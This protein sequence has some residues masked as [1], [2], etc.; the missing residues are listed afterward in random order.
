M[1]KELKISLFILIQVL[2]LNICFA[3]SNFEIANKYY[4]EDNYPSAKYY[5]EDSLFNEG[6]QNG[7]LFYRLGYSYEQLKF[8]KSTYSRLYCAAAYCFERDNDKENKYYSYAIAKENDLNVNHKNYTEE[9]LQKLIDDLYWGNHKKDFSYY[10]KHIKEF[11][12]YAIMILI[13]AIVIIVFIF[14][15]IRHFTRYSL[16]LKPINYSL[17]S[18]FKSSNFLDADSNF[19]DLLQKT[20]NSMVE[21]A[22][23][24]SGRIHASEDFLLYKF[25]QVLFTK[26]GH[27]VDNK[28]VTSGLKQIFFEENPTIETTKRKINFINKFKELFHSWRILQ[29]IYDN[30]LYDTPEVG[31]LLAV[32]YTKMSGD[33]FIYNANS[34]V[35]YCNKYEI[36]DCK[37]YRDDLLVIANKLYHE[38]CNETELSKKLEI[39]LFRNDRHFLNSIKLFNGKIVTAVSKIFPIFVFAYVL[40]LMALIS[41]ITFGKVVFIGICC[42]LFYKFKKKILDPFFEYEPLSK[43]MSKAEKEALERSLKAQAQSSNHTYTK[44]Q[45]SYTKPQTTYSDNDYEEEPAVTYKKQQ[46]QTEQKPKVQ[47]Q[48][49]YC[50]YCGKEYHDLFQLT[51]GHCSNNGNAYHTP[52]DGPICDKYFCEYCGKQYHDLFQLTHGHCSNNNN[53]KGYHIPYEGGIKNTYYCRNCGKQYHDLFQ[54]T[55]GHCS[56]N[57]N[58]KGYHQPRR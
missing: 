8:P 10:K 20:Y 12:Y 31:T 13:L 36:I 34:I 33:N 22:R 39:E 55:H 57:N 37:S 11:L 38:K 35:D 41:S 58:G 18:L 47:I 49:Y 19:N 46:P 56:N 43:L 48:K 7:T 23:Y 54:L 25:G 9:T 24:G 51:H 27:K 30:R 15:F 26:N 52:Y 3:E 40:V 44:T 16:R 4:D 5:F 6:I 1:K 50:K 14:K 17:S 29:K 2:F 53:G 45:S 28:I 42:F 21:D 32:L